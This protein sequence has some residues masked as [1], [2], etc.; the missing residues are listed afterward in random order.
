MNIKKEDKTDAILG[1]TP[2]QLFENLRNHPNY[3]SVKDKKWEIDHI[4]PIKAFNDF[5]ITD[6]R[7]INALD[8]LRP[9]LPSKN[10]LKSGWYDVN[11]FISYCAKHGLHIEKSQSVRKAI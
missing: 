7:I 1:Y 6:L 2:K 10:R 4:Q 3:E 9:C 8:N 11:H 5:Q